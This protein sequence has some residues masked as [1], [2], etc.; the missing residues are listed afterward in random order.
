MNHYAVNGRGRRTFLAEVV[1]NCQSN[2]TLV[3]ENRCCNN[4]MNVCWIVD[5]RNIL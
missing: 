2:F 1:R 5:Q 4:P 3:E